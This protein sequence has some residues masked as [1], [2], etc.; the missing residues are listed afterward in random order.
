MSVSYSAYALI[1][2]RVPVARFYHQVPIRSCAHEFD[3][4]YHYCPIC[5][6]PASQYARVPMLDTSHEA[7]QGLH[8]IAPTP[9]SGEPQYVYIADQ[10]AQ[11]DW[12]ESAG[13]MPLPTG[14]EVLAAYA[15]MRAVLEPVGLWD[16]T[17]FRLWVVLNVSY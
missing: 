17:Q 13:Q 15:K 11:T 8:V 10:Y 5:G 14:A 12:N 4:A 16:G 7:L 2:V 1:G 9:I 3:S 6:K